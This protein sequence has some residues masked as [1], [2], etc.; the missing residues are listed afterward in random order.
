MNELERDI[1]QRTWFYRFKLPSGAVTRSYD[2]GVLDAIHETRL[3]MMDGALAAHFPGGLH[4]VDA[5]DLACHQGYFSIEL[6]RR[7]CRAVLGLDARPDHVA[8]CNLMAQA[9]GLPGVRAVQSDV[10]AATAQA[11]GTHDLVLCFGLI[12]HL[13][14]PVGALRVARALTRPGGL[15]LVETQVVPNLSGPVDWGAYRFVKP[16]QGVFG[17]IDEADETHG[18]EASVTGI[19][20]A[21]SVEGLVWVLSRIG[22]RDIEVLAPPPDAYEQHRYGK[23]VMVKAVAA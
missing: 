19:C 20:L 14:N 12:Y 6:A 4:A 23:R 17:L 16:L 7:G 11:H 18:P 3:A 22:F 15:C 5:L 13:E 1:L 10:H 2:D 9:L 8:D 21:P